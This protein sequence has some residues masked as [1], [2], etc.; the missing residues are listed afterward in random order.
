MGEMTSSSFDTMIH[1]I[2]K[3]I[4][5]FLQYFLRYFWNLISDKNF[6]L[7][8]CLQIPPL[9]LCTQMAP[10]K[11]IER[12]QITRIRVSL[13]W[14]TS[15]NYIQK[16]VTVQLNEPFSKRVAN[17]A[18]QLG[19]TEVLNFFKSENQ[20]LVNKVTFYRLKPEDWWNIHK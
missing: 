1:S 11:V 9:D 2:Q 19:K 20:Q 7:T 13:W 15:T 17:W 14:S 18:T 12:T 5:S 3:F 8:S 4:T 16:F 10:E 6:E